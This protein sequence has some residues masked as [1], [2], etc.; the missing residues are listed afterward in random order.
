MVNVDTPDNIG[1]DVTPALNLPF[2]K[3]TPICRR[4]AGCPVRAGLAHHSKSRRLGA[5]KPTSR[6]TYTD[7]RADQRHE[8]S[9]PDVERNIAQGKR[10]AGL[11][12]DVVDLDLTGQ[13]TGS[14]LT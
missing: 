5:S 12:G 13:F 11:V 8:L 7:R 10:P 6:D 4:T 14:D 2:C 3:T 9:G 1:K